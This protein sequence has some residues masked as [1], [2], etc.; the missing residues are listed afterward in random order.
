LIEQEPSLRLYA[1]VV[2]ALALARGQL[3]SVKFGDFSQNDVERVLRGTSLDNIAA[4]LGLRE[5]D[6]AIDWEEALTRQERD[7]IGGYRD[8]HQT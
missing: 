4:A 8:P 5:D 1:A 3:Y 7:S 6:I 2:N